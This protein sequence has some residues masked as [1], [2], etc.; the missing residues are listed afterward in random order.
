MAT[1]VRADPGRRRH[2]DRIN[3]VG[4]VLLARQFD[5]RLRIN[6]DLQNPIVFVDQFWR[7]G[8]HSDMGIKSLLL[9]DLLR[10]AIVKRA[11]ASRSSGE[12]ND[13]DFDVLADGAV[14][15]RNSR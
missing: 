6:D 5:L 2:V 10:F 3:V 4:R 1:V 9:R 8:M 13:D 7:V 11:S 15:A 14:V 12:W